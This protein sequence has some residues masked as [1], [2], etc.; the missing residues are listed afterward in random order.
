MVG[1]GPC[2]W[3]SVLTICCD[4]SRSKKRKV[5]YEP[6]WQINFINGFLMNSPSLLFGAI[7]YATDSTGNSSPMVTQVKSFT[8]QCFR[9]QPGK[10]S[11]QSVASSCW[12]FGWATN[13]GGRKKKAC[14]WLV[15]RVSSS[16]S[17][18]DPYIKLWA[19]YGV[20]LHS[21]TQ[22]LRFLLWDLFNLNHPSVYQLLMILKASSKSDTTKITMSFFSS[23]AFPFRAF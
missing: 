14:Y 2:M 23:Y 15:L 22:D 19:G 21:S 3:R 10:P 16:L 18:R 4:A 12:Q 6:V 7:R 5:R 13:W 20:R 1:G 17:Y 8:A 9:L 11:Y